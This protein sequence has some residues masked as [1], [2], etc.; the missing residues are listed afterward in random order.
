MSF[1]YTA[2]IVM[3][4]LI[5]NS[6]DPRLSSNI[7]F[8]GID[9]RAIDV[10]QENTIEQRWKFGK[11]SNGRK[12][13]AIA[14][15]ALDCVSPALSLAIERIVGVFIAQPSKLSPGKP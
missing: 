1:L 6:D 7:K 15:I 11:G 14:N 4:N 10:I 3:Q 9:A 2:F 5:I 8:D 12:N 13:I